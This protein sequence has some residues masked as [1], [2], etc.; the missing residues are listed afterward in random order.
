MSLPPRS[1]KR[2]KAKKKKKKKCAVTDGRNTG[3]IIQLTEYEFWR[4]NGVPMTPI[5]FIGLEDETV[6]G[7]R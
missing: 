1:L 5:E 4:V 7:I 6:N 2:S 3:H